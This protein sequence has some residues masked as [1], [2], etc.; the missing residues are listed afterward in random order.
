MQHP[1]GYVMNASAGRA[2]LKDFFAVLINPTV[3][4]AFPHVIAG[5]FMTGGAFVLG[6]AVW[7]L[8]RRPRRTRRRSE[9]PPRSGAT[10]S[11]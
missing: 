5:A 1:V 2:E 7:R 11:C 6:V 3:L 10:A 4:L 9:R 8:L